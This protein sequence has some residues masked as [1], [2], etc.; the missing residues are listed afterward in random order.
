MKKSFS[1][2]SRSIFVV[3]AGVSAQAIVIGVGDIDDPATDPSYAY[4]FGWPQMVDGS[5]NPVQ[6]TFDADF[7]HTN[8]EVFK[9]GPAAVRAIAG[10]T[11]AMATI[12]FDFSSSGYAPTNVVFKDSMFLFGEAAGERT[13]G[14]T[15]YSTDGS[16]WTTISSSTTTNGSVVNSAGVSIALNSPSTVYYRIRF[17][18]LADDTSDG[19]NADVNQWAR[20]GAG[21]QDFQANFALIPEPASMGLLLTAGGMALALRRMVR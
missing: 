17:D 7:V 14:E 16:T 1:L 20:T 2:L 8:M 15:M 11:N 5:A 3:L 9:P 12:T 19:F 6:T 10:S 13:A 18:V 4:Q 21:A